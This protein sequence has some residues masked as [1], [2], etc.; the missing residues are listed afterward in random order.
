MSLQLSWILFQFEQMFADS[1]KVTT[2][3]YT[4]TVVMITSQW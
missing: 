3:V 1:I 2:G 4:I